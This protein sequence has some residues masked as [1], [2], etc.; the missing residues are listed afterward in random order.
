MAEGSSGTLAQEIA[1]Q[2]AEAGVKR[3]FGVPGGGSSLQLIAAAEEAGIPF[4]LSKTE[5][6]GAIMAAVTGELSGAPG[7]M[8]AGVGPGAASA[9]N[10][11]AYAHLERSPVIMFCDGPAASLHQAFDQN[12]LYQPVSKAQGRL[13]TDTGSA[14][15]AEGLAATLAHPRG[16]VQFDLTTTDASTMCVRAEPAIS[17]APAP[18]QPPGV[19]ADLIAS[20]R[21][22]VIIAGLETR[23]HDVAGAMAR[24]AD[25]LT[26]PMFTTY[27]AKGVVPD[28]HPNMVGHFTGAT[29]EAKCLDQAD[30][31]VC[32]GFDPVERIPS[33]WPYKAPVLELRAAQGAELPIDPAL[34]LVGDL[35]KL[36]DSIS[37]F[38]PSRPWKT[39]E[40]SDLHT[41]FKD[42]LHLS[43]GGHTAHTVMEQLVGLVSPDTR[44]TVDAGAHM[45]SAMALWPASE[46]NGVL[47]SNGLSTMGYALPAAIGSSLHEPD[48]PVVAV[49]GDGGMLMAL[50]EL[51]TTA[52][53]KCNLTLIV[54]NDAALSLIDLKQQ[55]LQMAS[56]GVRYP[57]TN[58]ATIAKGFGCKAWKVGQGDE[59]EPALRKALAAKGPAVV[60]VAIDPSGYRDQFAALRG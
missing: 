32:I 38:Q 18:P 59:L 26:C 3:M 33:P 7:A 40:I 47:K 25:R 55:N 54:L 2:M 27:R 50:A 6:G 37:E 30:L 4:V 16:P 19:W 35:A 51:A 57:A 52:E 10:G 41:S 29:L 60:D 13:S 39:E 15:F 5:T 42:A 28:Q 53:H 58:F 17:T 23:D 36:I 12:A 14:L 56:K 20:S 24:L 44:L 11:I 49:T 34:S 43:A 46:T 9:V 21:K 8:L 31:I 45:V 1:R 22:P 48:R